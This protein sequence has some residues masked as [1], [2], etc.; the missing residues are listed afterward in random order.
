MQ[1]TP[2]WTLE[3][4]EDMNGKTGEIQVWNSVNSDAPMSVSWF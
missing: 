2:D 1:C 3:Q 4:K